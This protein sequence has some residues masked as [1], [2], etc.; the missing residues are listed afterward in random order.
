MRTQTFRLPDVGEGIAEAEITAWH[1][2]VGDRIEE[3]QP[4]VD[5]MTDKATVEIPSP[6]SGRIVALHGGAGEMCAIGAALVEFETEG[7]AP[8][9]SERPSATDPEP[10]PEVHVAPVEAAPKAPKARAQEQEAAEP[11]PAPDTPAEPTRSKPTASPVVRQRAKDLGIDLGQV[12]GSGPEGR[13]V[14]ADLDASLSRGGRP[15]D[16]TGGDEIEEV[17][18]IGLRRKIAERMQEAKRHIPHFSY[19]EEVEVGALEDLRRHLNDT[20]RGARPRLSPLPF[21]MLAMVAALREFPQINALFDDQAGIVHRYRSVHIGIATQTD[22]G[23]MVPVVRQVETRDLWSCAAE[24]ARLAEAARSGKAAREEL[25]GSTITI[26]SLGALGGLVTTPV[27]NRPEVA[28]VGLNK[29]HERPI[30]RSGAVVPARM[31]NIS[32][33]FD[34]RVVDGW[35]AAEFVQR[36]KR[37]LEQPAALFIG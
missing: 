13:V 19:V 5:V 15:R 11:K 17:R 10:T 24:I 16:T 2:A 27:I 25:S 12:T 31:M 35:H 3:D 18:V 7:E 8:T 4:L 21:V 37:L 33:S 9:A 36:L 29:I 22:S 14:H 6:L 20:H 30:V 1:V 34:H 26:T 28:I 32:A 23:L